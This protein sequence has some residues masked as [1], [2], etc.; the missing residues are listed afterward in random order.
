MK[1]IS[2]ILL[3]G[4]VNT[5]LV[6]GKGVKSVS[7]VLP[8]S[9]GIFISSHIFAELLMG[10]DGDDEQMKT[11]ELSMRGY[12]YVRGMDLTYEVLGHVMRD[13]NV[14]GLM[15]EPHLGRIVQSCDRALLYDAVSR[16]EQRRLVH[17]GPTTPNLLI[18][19]G[20]VRLI[21]LACIW[22]FNHDQEEDF[23]ATAAI[24]H[25]ETLEKVFSQMD[26]STF[27]YIPNYLRKRQQNL[28]LLPAVPSV[29]RPIRIEIF[30]QRQARPYLLDMFKIKKEH[31]KKMERLRK[32]RLSAGTR[33]PESLETEPTD[34]IS[35]A[36][37]E[38]PYV[39]TTNRSRLKKRSNQQYSIENSASRKL[40][41]AYEDA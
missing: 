18:D 9:L 16:M 41:L 11:L 22:Y 14:I 8:S 23:K 12:Q 37:E 20:K 7:L 25:W 26:P 29:E 28:H 27:Y 34:L 6:S 19:N 13:G 24:R 40:L 2:F 32:L 5:G 21:N 30:L 1:T 39:V 36:V 10:W 4:N 33:V 15:T 38:R 3:G 35:E 17:M 31:E